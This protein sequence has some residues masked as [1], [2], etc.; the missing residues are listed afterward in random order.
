MEFRD[1][2]F[3]R[4]MT[5]AFRPE[6]VPP[7]IVARIVDLAV[8]APTAG[9]SAGVEWLVLV[10]PDDVR[11]FFA[12][13]SD[14]GFLADPG[15]MAGLLNAA[16]VLLP[17][18]D[19]AAYVA[20]YAERDKAGSGLAGLAAGDWP[21]PYW[22]VDAAFSAMSVLLSAEDEGLGALFFR[23]HRPAGE[24]ER[25]FGVPKGRCLIGAIALGWAAEAGGSEGSATRRTRPQASMVHFGRW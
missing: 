20:R 4:R 9:K 25:V 8:R 7:E 11:S 21:V 3:R 10:E 12:A 18:A 13:T 22:L 24:L 2:V 5:R 17:V 6:P 15:A 19:A 14:E 16:A 1:V 23:L